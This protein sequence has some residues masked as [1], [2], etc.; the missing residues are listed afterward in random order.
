MPQIKIRSFLFKVKK[1]LQTIPYHNLKT[2]HSNLIFTSEE[3]TIQK[4]EY[5]APLGK[6]DHS[7]L[8]FSIA[9]D[10]PYNPP[11]IK[12][13]YDKG[14]YETMLNSLKDIDWLAEFS[15]YP[16]CVEKQ[17]VFFKHKYHEIEKTCIPRKN[18]FINGKISKNLST[19]L[20]AKSISKIKKKNKIWGKIRKNLATLEEQLQYKRLRNQIRNLTRK[21]KKL[22]EKKLLEMLNL[23]LKHSGLMH[24]PN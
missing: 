3:G 2:K 17:W 14:D 19:P 21:S 4:L 6:S 24:N 13:Q 8:K 12:I 23:I 16:D 18:V 22:V 10:T 5:L 11:K 7:I 20:D 9:C 1:K 15:K